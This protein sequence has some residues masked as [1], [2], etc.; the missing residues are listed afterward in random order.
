MKC[1]HILLNSVF[2]LLAAVVATGCKEKLN[3]VIDFGTVTAEDTTYTA[4]IETPQWRRVLIEEFT[5]VSCPPCPKGHI[6]LQSIIAQHH[7]AALDIDSV[8]VIGIQSTGI[9]QANPVDQPPYFSRNDNRTAAGSEIYNT[10]YGTFGNI[11]RAGVDRVPVD[12]ALAMNRDLWANNVTARLRV[13]TPVNITLTSTYNEDSRQAVIKV[14]LAYTSAVARQQNLNLAIVEDDIIDA[15]KND[16]IVDSM[17]RHEH[18]LRDM[19]TIATGT[20]IM[21]DLATKEAGRV[22]ERTFIY[23][24]NTSWAPEKCRLIAFVTNNNGADKEVQQSAETHL[25]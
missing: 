13:P 5:G 4:P 17:Y 2:V 11:P 7:N 18:V 21:N 19:L 24:V 22:Y 6:A 25:K 1:R 9:P 15:Q 20:P 12:G 23:T 8:S 16:L 14:R 10:I 3:N